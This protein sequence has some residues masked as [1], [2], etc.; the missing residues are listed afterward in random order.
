ME[1]IEERARSCRLS[2]A[3]PFRREFIQKKRKKKERKEKKRKRGRKF[4][5]S[6]SARGIIARKE[7]NSGSSARGA[8]LQ[9]IKYA[10][11]SSF[12]SFHFTVALSETRNT[13]HV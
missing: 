5:R 1:M 12:I 7:F 8:I 3:S 6:V 11:I 10:A 13:K 2:L 4:R 9:T